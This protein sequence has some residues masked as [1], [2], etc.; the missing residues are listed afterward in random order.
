MLP[1]DIDVSKVSA[2]Y[3]NGVLEVK[4]A[5]KPESVTAKKAI[6]IS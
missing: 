2:N 4:V 5:K 1:R 3:D 6:Q